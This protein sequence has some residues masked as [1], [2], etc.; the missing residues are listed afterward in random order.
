MT[1]TERKGERNKREKF[2]VAFVWPETA[3]VTAFE[4]QQRERDE[5]RAFPWRATPG[6]TENDHAV[7]HEPLTTRVCARAPF[8]CPSNV[9]VH[10]YLFSVPHFLSLISPTLTA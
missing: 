4:S 9:F 8:H 3:K 7:L 6:K 10:V 1:I 2:G 5:A